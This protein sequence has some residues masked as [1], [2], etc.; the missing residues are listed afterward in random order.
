MIRVA[1][2]NITRPANTT[3]YASGQRIWTGTG[4]TG[5]SGITAAGSVFYNL[6]E[7]MFGN[8][9]IVKAALFSNASGISAAA[10]RLHLYTLSSGQTLTS[11]A[12]GDGVAMTFS[13]SDIN[14]YVGFID[15]PAASFVTG[16]PSYAQCVV[17]ASLAFQ[18]ASIRGEGD[19]S[20]YGTA[21][22]QV[23]V[24]T[25]VGILE[26]RGAWTPT[27]GQFIS[28]QLTSEAQEGVSP[29]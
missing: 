13:Y 1:S 28:V 12:V 10:Q 3:A 9:Y 8:G 22:N 15:F 6:G 24:G 4:A 17:T 23:R 27:S 16:G 2:I 5:T 14:Q 7:T 26:A 29:P 25:L 18:R 11:G 20:G 19:F 21:P